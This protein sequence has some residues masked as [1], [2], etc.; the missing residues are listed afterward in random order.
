M[1]WAKQNLEKGDEPNL[2]LVEI[3]I[4]C[5]HID[6]QKLCFYTSMCKNII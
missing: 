6:V 3:E 5:L 1:G 2:L 4:M